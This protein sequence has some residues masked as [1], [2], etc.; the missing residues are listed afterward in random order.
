MEWCCLA[1]DEARYEIKERSATEVTVQVTVE[2]EAV[3]RGIDAVYNRYGREVAIPGF[4]K[5][6][7]PR[8]FLD[9]RFGR[10]TFVEQ[11][12]ETLEEEHLQEALT[13]LD[14]R[15]VSRPEPTV[16]SFEEEG[17]FVF[18][19]QF[20]VLP[21]I[22]LPEYRGLELEVKPE[23]PVTDEDV[24]GTLEEIRRRFATL[25]PKDG[26]TVV[27][28]EIVHVKEGEEEFDL[29][30]SE[31]DPIGR[32]LIG[33]EVGSAVQ[34]E[35]ERPGGRS[36]HVPLEVLGLR[37]LVLPEIDDEL[38]K[39]AGADTLDALKADIRERLASAKAR[40]RE[41]DIKDALLDKVVEAADVPLPEPMVND[42]VDE[43]IASFKKELSETD[44]PTPFE[45]YL[46]REGKSEEDL[47]TQAR[48]AIEHR[49][50]RELVLDK[51]TE[52]EGIAI[53][54]EEIAEIAKADAEAAGED[55]LRFTA[56]LK[57][58]ERWDDYREG[59]V[60]ARVFDLLYES[61]KLGEAP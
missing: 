49:M 52:A 58:Q 42:L 25:A 24:N 12:Q 30:V 4:R 21:E 6:H 28:G 46:E 59:K 29:S 10:E 7:V 27:A 35:L 18:T 56:R 31:D 41:R 45:A 54:D 14:L 2:P 37:E 5:G 3:K 60:R 53:S 50:R 16:V 32:Q 33:A 20:S 61:A 22:T 8:N 57:A 47:R 9:L 26:E 43:E 40:H 36:R 1:N 11:A 17:P 19:T 34:I 48:E 44:P 15:P 38:A 39:D 13:Q 55:P 23:E 51:I